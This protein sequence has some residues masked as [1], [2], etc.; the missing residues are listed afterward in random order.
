MTLREELQ[1]TFD[2]EQ[3]RLGFKS[4]FDEIDDIFFITDY[5]EQQR[6]V[7]KYFSR[8]LCRRI[9][10]TYSSWANL[11]HRLLMPN[12]SSLPDMKESK[13]ITEEDKRA[14]NSI[15]AK[16]ME[17]SSRNSLIGLNKDEEEEAKFIDEAVQF[18]NETAQKDIKNVLVKLNNAWK[19]EDKED[20]QNL[21]ESYGG[22]S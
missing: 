8:Q 14:L 6:F 4:T 7:S 5:I 15:L 11:S 19:E 21:R 1:Q 16:I 22:V 13:Y 20:Q 10:E 17:L 2:K 3:K 12:P 9:V 18:W